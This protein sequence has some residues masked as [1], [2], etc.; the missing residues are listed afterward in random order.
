VKQGR[1]GKIG[2]AGGEQRG[3]EFGIAGQ[4]KCFQRDCQR[5]GW[6]MPVL[7]VWAKGYD[8]ARH[9]PA[10]I[11]LGFALCKHHRR[12]FRT[13]DI[14]DAAGWQRI[15]DGFAAAGKAEP[16]R[17]SIELRWEK[18]EGKD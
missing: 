10:T 5:T 18:I 6:W 15:V 7:L 13:A 11:K 1:D 14:V 2:Y 4:G 8:K 16:D 9:V 3:G 17:E 12:E